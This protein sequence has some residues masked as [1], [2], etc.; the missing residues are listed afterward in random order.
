MASFWGSFSNLIFEPLFT[1]FV[2]LGQ[3]SVVQHTIFPRGNL[4]TYFNGLRVTPQGRHFLTCEM[5]QEYYTGEIELF[6]GQTRC[7]R[8]IHTSQERELQR[9]IGSVLLEAT[10]PSL[11]YHFGG[12]YRAKS[13]ASH[14][15][16]NLSSV[17]TQR[18][19]YWTCPV[20]WGATQLLV[21]FPVVWG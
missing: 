9:S 19:P 12:V 15:A 20:P 17:H 11:C 3:Q 8:D 13:V 7:R 2:Q 21:G 4:N 10:L 14:Q 1:K 6:Q 18:Q 5:V 16:E